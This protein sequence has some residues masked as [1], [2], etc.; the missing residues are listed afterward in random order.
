LIIKI[1]NFALKTG[2]KKLVCKTFFSKIAKIVDET[3]DRFVKGPFN[4][5]ASA[6]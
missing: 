4:F 2:H 5:E 6:A 3:F 1:V